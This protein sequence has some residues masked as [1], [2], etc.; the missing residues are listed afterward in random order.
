MYEYFVAF[1][2]QVDSRDIRFALL[3]EM[4]HLLGTARSFDGTT[5]YLPFQLEQEVSSLGSR[6][7]LDYIGDT[8]WY[9]TDANEV[10]I[11]SCTSS[12]NNNKRNKLPFYATII[13]V[14]D[15]LIPAPIVLPRE[16]K[17]NNNNI[18]FI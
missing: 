6:F 10:D 7:P 11:S 1:Q 13:W 3:R 8:I 9:G 4:E 16:R 5:L 2:P 17:K 12:D 15:Q 18:I 14:L